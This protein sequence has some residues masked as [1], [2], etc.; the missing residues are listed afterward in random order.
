MLR[1]NGNMRPNMFHPNNIT[2][3]SLPLFRTHVET[4]SHS[5][6]FNPILRANST[7]MTVKAYIKWRFAYAKHDFAHEQ[8]PFCVALT[9]QDEMSSG[10]LRQIERHR[11]MEWSLTEQQLDGADADQ[12]WTIASI[13]RFFRDL[14]HVRQSSTVSGDIGT[15][16]LCSTHQFAPE[17]H[18]AR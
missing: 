16:R 11:S 18:R 10:G 15:H 2:S 14:E 6:I 12:W 7:S 9:A 5:D 3:H 13:D 8:V 1:L 17:H 4:S